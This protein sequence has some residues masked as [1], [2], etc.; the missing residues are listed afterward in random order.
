M[1]DILLEFIT[2]FD[3]TL[4][5]EQISIDDDNQKY[6]ETIIDASDL[7]KLSKRSI[8]TVNAFLNG[9]FDKMNDRFAQIEH[10]FNQ[11]L[12][13]QFY[14]KQLSCF[15]EPAYKMWVSDDG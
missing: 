15:G 11:R 8:N 2:E 7:A 1:K 14:S 3:V 5:I 6:T 4:V 13:E 12:N 9:I 10:D